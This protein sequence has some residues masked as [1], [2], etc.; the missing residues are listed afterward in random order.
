MASGRASEGRATVEYVASGC[1]R[2]D[3]ADVACAMHDEMESEQG[4][5]EWG[6]E[7]SEEEWRQMGMGDDDE[8]GSGWGSEM[9]WEEGEWECGGERSGEPKGDG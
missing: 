9:E 5:S 4:G 8:A 2:E 3:G 6:S 1:G 7:V